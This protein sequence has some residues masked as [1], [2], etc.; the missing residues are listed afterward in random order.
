MN[1]DITRLLELQK[2]LAAFNQVERVTHR[3]HGHEYVKENDTEHSY[4]LAITAW[5]LAQSFPDLDLQLLLKYSLVHDL[6]EVYAG[7]TYI[8]GDDADLQS[9]PQREADALARLENEWD[10]FDEM[11]LAIKDYE[12]KAN[13]EARFVYALDKVMPIMLIYIHDGYTWKQEDVTAAMLYTA[14]RDKVALS[15]E[16]MPYFESIYNLLLSNPELIRKT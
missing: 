16:I 4:N 11:I 2:L 9:K 12:N 1:P 10:D 3:K 7:D 5:F 13:A 15:P 6:V 8:Y 14:K